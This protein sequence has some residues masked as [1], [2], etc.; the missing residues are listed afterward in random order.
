MPVTHDYVEQRAGDYWI[1]GT[2]V[3]L[4]SLVQVFRH[5]AAPNRPSPDS[6][7]RFLSNKSMAPSPSTLLIG[8]RLTPSLQRNA[9][10][11]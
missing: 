6:T 8:P 4:N 10:G 9:E 3:S 11:L 1:T 7:P 2:Q 5:G